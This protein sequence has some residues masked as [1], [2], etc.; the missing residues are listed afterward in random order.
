MP[1]ELPPPV[2][3]ARFFFALWLPPAIASQLHSFSGGVVGRCGGRLMREDALHITL[4]FL[5]EVAENRLPELHEIAAA[6]ELP[7]AQV[8][9][10]RVG[11]W[12]HNHVL[13][14]GSKE[15]APVLEKLAAD[16][17]KTLV[18]AGFLGE[19]KPFVP[20]VTLLRKLLHP[21]TLPE[22][23]AHE[24]TAEEFVLARSWPSDRGSA[25][26]V[27]ARWPLK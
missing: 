18:E 3:G 23:Q 16:L 27:V 22:I 15:P 13:W 5:G 20:H 8:Q 14:A 6:V 26:E 21:G 19:V 24:W 12:N 11:F 10:D 4:A 7:K 1:N 2:V 17:Q 9:L 25:Y